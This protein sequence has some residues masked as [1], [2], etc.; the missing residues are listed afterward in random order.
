MHAFLSYNS[1]DRDVVRR[2]GAQM[3]LAGY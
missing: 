1:L 3:K 2:V